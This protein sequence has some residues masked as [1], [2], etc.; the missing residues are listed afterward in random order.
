[1]SNNTLL[2]WIIGASLI[3]GVGSLIGGVF[4]LWQESLARRISLHLVTLAAG[5]LLGVAFLD[6][7]PEAFKEGK[8][9]N[10]SP[11]TLLIWALFG[12]IIFFLIELLLVR[13][14]T[15]EEERNLSG[16]TTTHH[17]PIQNRRTLPWLVT[18]GDSLHNFVDGVA[19][20]AGFLVSPAT[21]ILTAVAV[22]AH[23]IPQEVSDFSILLHSG[24]SRRQV[25][26]WNIIAAL[27]STIGALTAY[28]FRATV[29]NILAPL[30]AFT[31]GVFI[32]IAASDLFPDIHH[33]AERDKPWH[34][35][36]ALSLGIGIVWVLVKFIGE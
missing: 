14:H 29:E 7:M 33:H 31:A 12:I 32:Y 3:G 22:A 1:M 19:I 23:E 13:L 8:L 9:T 36:V 25:L 15:H 27:G 30:L 11:E 34:V 20:T 24:W 6:L 35:L 16:H 28:N 10:F 21:G 2:L 5:T 4:L 26:F 18:I 17:S